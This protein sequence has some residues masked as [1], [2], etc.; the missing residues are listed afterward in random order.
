VPYKKVK[1]SLDDVY[2]LT[3]MSLALKYAGRKSD[4]EPW[5]A[6][7]QLNY[8]HNLRLQFLAGLGLNAAGVERDKIYKSMLAYRRYPDDLFIASEQHERVLRAAF[9]AK[10]E[11]LEKEESTAE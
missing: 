10:Q 11:A 6:D 1:E 8:D 7:A 2:F 5:L 9:E 4:L 3:V